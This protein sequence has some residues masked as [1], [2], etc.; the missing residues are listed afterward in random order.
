MV[1]SLKP[2]RKRLRYW[3]EPFSS[4]YAFTKWKYFGENR[5]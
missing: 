1:I 4:N 2:K 3:F 5:A